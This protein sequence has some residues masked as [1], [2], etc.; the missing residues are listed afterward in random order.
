MP[1]TSND[2]LVNNPNDVNPIYQMKKNE[3]LDE[4]NDTPF[5]A[6]DGVRDK[7]NDTY[8][9]GDTN[10]DP[11][12]L[13]N[14]GFQGAAEINLPDDGQK[15]PSDVSLLDDDTTDDDEDDDDDLKEE[16]EDVN[17]DDDDEDTEEE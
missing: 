17:E 9:Q 5:S 16:A 11:L 7:V 1:D 13:Y 12:Q 2:F 3:K 8:Q 14:E 15:V 4:D 10:I 6:P